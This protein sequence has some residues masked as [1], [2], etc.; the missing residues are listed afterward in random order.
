LNLEKNYVER[1]PARKSYSPKINGTEYIRK[2]IELNIGLF[3]CSIGMYLTV[4]ANCGL[5]PWIAL[6]VGFQ[7]ITG[8]NYGMWTN[9][10]GIVIILADF[11]LKEKIGFATL[12]DAL[13]IGSYVEIMNYFHILPVID[14]TFIGI[15]VMLLGIAIQDFGCFFYMD[16]GFGEGPRD[17]LMVALA[18]R[19]KKLT[20]GQVRILLEG[21]VLVAGFLLGAKIGAGTVIFMVGAG[22]I[23]DLEF[24]LLKFDVK[25]V[26]NED[27]IDTVRNICSLSTAKNKA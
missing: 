18:R 13:L 22:A 3:I 23:L 4:Q 24:F 5:A 8:I 1:F 6:A 7:N 26:L 15:L 14:N 21:T 27:M 2:F 12:G 20:V 17:A 9:I 19:M 10:I 16:A 11:L 25:R